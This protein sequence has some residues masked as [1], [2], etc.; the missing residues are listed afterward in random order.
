M[1]VDEITRKYYSKLFLLPTLEVLLVIYL[2]IIVAVGLINAGSYTLPSMVSS[3]VQ[4]LI[5]GA[6]LLV[7][8]STLIPTKVF[9]FKRVL[10]LST[11]VFIVSL[12]AELIFY[13]LTGYKGT[14]ILASSGLAFV[15]L[16]AFFHVAVAIAIPFLSSLTT[17][18]VIN[19]F[20]GAPVGSGEMLLATSAAA[21]SLLLGVAY[22]AVIEGKGRKYGYSPVSLLRSFL[23][24]WFTGDPLKFEGELSKYGEEGTL[25]VK[26]MTL[27]RENEL[28]IALVFPTLHF[29]P[30]RDVGSSRFIYHVE[31]GSEAGMKFFVFHTPGSHEHNLVSS[32]E[33]LELGR[34]VGKFASVLSNSLAGLKLCRPFRVR[35]GGW[36]AFVLPGPTALVAFLV[37]V[38][39]GNDDLSYRLWDLAEG[40]AS[41]PLMTALVDSHSFKGDKVEDVSEVKPLLSE[42]F[43]EFSCSEG[44]DFLA[45]YGEAIAPVT[46]RGICNGV[47]KVLSLNFSGDRYG[48]VYIYGNNMDGNYRRKLIEAVKKVGFKDV[49]VVTPDDHSCAA[50]IKESPYD[51]VTECEGLTK[52]VVEAAREAVAN[53]VP[54]KY[55]T[56]EAVYL[57]SRF[58]GG[59][60]WELI[61]GLEELGRFA[62][63]GLSALAF[64]INA[65]PV[66]LNLG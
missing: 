16:T 26:I 18:K 35:V 50:S 3:V 12:P 40:N 10:G 25:R 63:R 37:N 52:A 61:A 49:E 51:I 33:S 1:R 56:L 66:I 28:P 46:C 22:V 64:L 27:L 58:I 11:V 13:R 41:A 24:T 42:V 47:V 4:Y 20:F 38:D 19:D 65:T 43:K 53:E 14:G 2:A 21:T 60:V 5:V 15:I 45:G 44:E 29:G 55:G 34:E 31:E 62:L 57:K 8:Y 54:A 32:R 9:N 48:I 30:F 59:K 17:F 36:E 39:K 6:V 23:N 7:M